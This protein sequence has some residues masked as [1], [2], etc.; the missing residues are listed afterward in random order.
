[1]FVP[2]D[3]LYNILHGFLLYGTYFTRGYFTYTFESTEGKFGGYFNLNLRREKFAIRKLAC[4]YLSK[5][6]GKPSK[7]KI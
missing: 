2:R 7:L 3:F 5:I 6:I 1:M 4:T